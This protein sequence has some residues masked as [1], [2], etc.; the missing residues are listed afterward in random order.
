MLQNNCYATIKSVENKG[1][2]SVV[3]ISISMKDKATGQYYTSFYGNVSFVGEAHRKVGAEGTKIKITKFG[4]SN[5]YLDSARQQ[6]WTDRPKVTVFDFEFEGANT[7]NTAA[8]PTA[9]STLD[10]F[11][12]D[13]LPF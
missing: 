13:S 3:K 6:K 11:Q 12:E 8:V 4:I 7:G 5:G 2:Y 1:K 10:T 9:H